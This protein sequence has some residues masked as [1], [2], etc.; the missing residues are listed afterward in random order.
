MDLGSW[1]TASGLSDPNAIRN[2]YPFSNAVVYALG[3]D[4]LSDPDDA[5]PKPSVATFT[6]NGI[7]SDYLTLTYTRRAGAD[8]ALVTPEVSSDL[9]TWTSGDPAGTVT[10]SRHLNGDGTE[11]LTVRETQPIAAR[12]FVRLKVHVP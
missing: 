12:R 10:V 8:D 9:S 7:T 2:G 11:T 4:L 5:L 6:V 1:L 3:A